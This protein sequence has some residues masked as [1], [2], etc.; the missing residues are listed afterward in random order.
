ML[1]QV[2]LSHLKNE[3]SEEC[4]LLVLLKHL[5]VQPYTT[6]IFQIHVVWNVA[7]WDSL[8]FAQIPSHVVEDWI[9]RR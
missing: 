5:G 6:E 2:I 8:V 7:P 1:I 4:I 9:H 3:V